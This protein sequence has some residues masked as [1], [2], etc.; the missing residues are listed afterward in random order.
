[1]AAKRKGILGVTL[2]MPDRDVYLLNDDEQDVLIAQVGEHLTEELRKFV[3]GAPPLSPLRYQVTGPHD[4]PIQGPIHVHTLVAEFDLDAL[5]LGCAAR[6]TDAK[7][8]PRLGQADPL[9]DRR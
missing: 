7:D 9:G 5:P 4:D 1:M 6:E 3:G 2:A 8:G